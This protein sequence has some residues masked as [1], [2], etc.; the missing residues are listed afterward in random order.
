MASMLAG[1]S[2]VCIARRWR[3]R[4]FVIRWGPDASSNVMR[5]RLRCA[6]CG[7]RGAVIQHPGWMGA[8]IGEQPFPAEWVG[9]V[10]I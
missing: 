1:E 2:P 10:A 9:I 8:Q 6:K 3:S 4:P 5:E 7:H